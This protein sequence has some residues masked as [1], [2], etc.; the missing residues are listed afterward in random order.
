MKTQLNSEMKHLVSIN[1]YEELH[2]HLLRLSWRQQIAIQL[3]FWEE[4]SIFQV[5]NQL[6]I[7]WKEADDLIE[8]ALKTLKDRLVRSVNKTAALVA[9]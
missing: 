2:K 1:N 3:R 7:S 6:G 8:A 5:A 9:A 4:C